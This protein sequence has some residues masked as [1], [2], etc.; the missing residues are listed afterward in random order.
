M[1]KRDSEHEGRDRFLMDIDRITNEGLAGGQDHITHGKRQIEES[2][3][4][5]KENPPNQSQQD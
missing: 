2:Q 3:D 4:L 5:K 1:T